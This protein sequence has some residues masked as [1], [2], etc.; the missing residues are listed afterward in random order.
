MITS[1]M[2]ANDNFF[3]QF[4]QYADVNGIIAIPALHSN[5]SIGVKLRHYKDSAINIAGGES[6]VKRQDVR[7]H[8]EQITTLIYPVISVQPFVPVVDQSRY[9][10]AK[11][12]FGGL[13]VKDS[14]A[15]I[16]DSFIRVIWIGRTKPVSV[17]TAYALNRVTQ[18]NTRLVRVTE[19]DEVGQFNTYCETE[20]EDVYYEYAHP[21][22]FTFM[23]QVSFASKVDAHHQAMC[24]WAYKTFDLTNQ[25]C[26]VYNREVIAGFYVKGDYCGYEVETREIPRE[27]GVFEFQMD[28]KVTVYIALIDP[29]EYV[30][31]VVQIWRAGISDVE[32]TDSSRIVLGASPAIQRAV[33]EIQE[34]DPI[35]SQ[36]P[37]FTITEQ[38]IQRWES[39]DAYRQIVTNESVI[40]VAHNLG[41]FP[42]VTFINQVGNII[43]GAVEYTNE[44]TLILRFNS[45]QS[46]VVVC[47]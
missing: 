38:D 34:T 15:T 46:G 19:L 37:A 44:N 3:R 25:G 39:R 23:Y 17:S 20:V 14:Q 28:F 33:T 7:R 47:S 6:I 26:F 45:S 18:S 12:L 29:V 4:S 5:S 42:S 11:R 16:P 31:T 9:F 2:D 22:P 30:R 36:S 21:I 10:H 41:M 24:Q 35:F 8:E 40:T 32:V 13:K 43:E 27:D 1:I